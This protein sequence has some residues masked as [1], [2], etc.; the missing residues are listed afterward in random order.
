MKMTDLSIRALPD[1]EG[2]AK[3]IYYDDTLP[4]FGVRVSGSTKSF[5][6]TH[7]A[8]RT[9]ETIGRIGIITLSDARKEAKRRLAEYTL[10]KT[11]PE[12]RSW[13][14]ATA[15]Y[16]GGIKANRK[17]RTHEDYS[18]LLALFKFGD[19]RLTEIGQQD[20]QRDLDKLADRPAEHQHAFVVLRAFFNWCHQRHYVDRNPMERMKPPH[21][22]T[23]RER[24]LTD[25][26]LIKVWNACGD[27]TFGKIV[28]LLILTGQR[29]GEIAQLTT[30]MIGDDTITLP[31]WL[32][33]NGR[34][35]SLPL[36]LMSKSILTN[37]QLKGA[38]SFLFPARVSKKLPT[39]FNGWSKS[40]N[41]LDNRCGV[42]DWT[43]HD[44]RR[45]FA[46]GL[47]RLGVSIPVIEQLLNHVS[48]TR[49]GIVGVYNRHSYFPEMKQA[50]DL[51]DAHITQLTKT[52]ILRA[53]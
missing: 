6:L 47:Q 44:L 14:T 49:A 53:A 12:A 36:G 15:E 42:K 2:T 16:L 31:T 39:T 26:E 3:K 37:C 33:K 50:V 48:G 22:Y 25:F 46:T 41:S 23:A 24:V 1:Q 35:H 29:R 51:W 9:R 30:D 13:S 34:E 17:P 20:L 38:T 45:T 10:G 27:D 40:K 52:A 18:R 19:T 4:G 11:L 5:I 7:G 21:K 8:R 43:L 28:K 32:T